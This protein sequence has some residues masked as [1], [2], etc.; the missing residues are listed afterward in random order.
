MCSKKNRRRDTSNCTVS[1]WYD[2][3]LLFV[4]DGTTGSTTA[5][6]VATDE[7][8]EGVE[9]LFRAIMDKSIAMIVDIHEQQRVDLRCRRSRSESRPYSLNENIFVNIFVDNSTV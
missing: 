4:D 6:V 5:L 7:E 8:D 2:V 1:I 3:D 9:D